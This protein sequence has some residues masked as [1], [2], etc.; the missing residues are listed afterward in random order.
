MLGIRRGHNFQAVGARGYV[1]EE[2]IAEEIKNDVIKILKKH[3]FKHI[4]CS[5]SKMSKSEDLA[6][7]VKMCN[8]NKCNL[9]ASIHLNASKTTD[10]AVGCEVI[11][12]N[13]KFKEA[14]KVC[15]NLEKLGFKN[16]GVKHNKN[17]YELK[18]T[19][20]RAMIIEVCF[21]DSKADTDLLKE[22]GTYKIA[23]AI[24]YAIMG[25]EEDMTKPIE[26]VNAN[27]RVCV[28]SFAEYNNAVN[29]KKE[30]EKMGIECFI[31]KKED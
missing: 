26:Q 19:N 8:D 21:V 25:V 28:G 11:T 24:A 27:Y 9:F 3:N 22:L 10:K 5:P 1:K 14:T 17:F 29:K 20:C 7:G 12:Y 31:I 15:E 16:R 4:D 23:K 2:E 30:L 13:T 6:F 18:N